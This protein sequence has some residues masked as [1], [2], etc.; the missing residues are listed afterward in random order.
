MGNA[1]TPEA[2]YSSARSAGRFVFFEDTSY[3]RCVLTEWGYLLALRA[4]ADYGF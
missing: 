2:N 3:L 1:V 4:P